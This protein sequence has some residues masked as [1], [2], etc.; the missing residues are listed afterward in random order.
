MLEGLE[1]R[2]VPS[3]LTVQNNYDSGTSSLR[4]AISTAHNG[5]TI[6]F[7]HSLNGQ[8]ITLTT[9]KFLLNRSITIAGPGADQLTISGN[10]ASRV[11][12]VAARTTV[13]L[14]GLTISNGQ[15]NSGGGINNSGTLT[16]SACTL[17]NNLAPTSTGGGIYNFGALTVTSSTISGNT[18]YDDG[19]GIYNVGTAIVNGGSTLTGNSAF[20]GGAIYA[21][22]GTVTISASTLSN[23]SATYGG[24]GVYVYNASLTVN[25]STLTSNN[26]SSAGGGIFVSVGGTLTLKNYSTITGNTAPASFGPD[27][28]NQGVVYVDS[29]SVIGILDGNPP[30]PI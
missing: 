3:T 30:I 4:A 7:A 8:T 22:S 17:S 18:A 20:A 27:V 13:T 15:A 25:R 1:Q 28:Y 2:W 24:G 9:G 21:G 10:H 23:N 26:A 16:I 14:S 19:G 5:D 12:E 29:T 11:F 6:V